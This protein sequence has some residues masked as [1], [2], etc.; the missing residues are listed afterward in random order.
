[1]ERLIVIGSYIGA[2]SIWLSISLRLPVC[3]M[4]GLSGTSGFARRGKRP[5]QRERT[6]GKVHSGFTAAPVR[7][8]RREGLS[9]K[10]TA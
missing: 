4:S 6:A 3:L 7:A 5:F 1:M 8:D 2:M 9:K 10:G